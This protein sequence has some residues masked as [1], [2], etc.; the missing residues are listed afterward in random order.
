[1]KLSGKSEKWGIAI[2]G[3]VSAALVVNLGLQLGGFRSGGS[4]AAGAS[5][6]APGARAEN[7]RASDD[8]MKYDPVIH[9]DFLK[10]LQDR[11]MPELE[12]NPF[13]FEPTPAE[14]SA[15]AAAEAARASQPPPPPPVLLKPIGYAERPGGQREA[16]A[17]YQD[18]IYVVH[19]GDT[20]A[21][22]YKVMGIT[23]SRVT[24][25]D[26]STHETLEIPI[27]Q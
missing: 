26:V 13:D 5:S 16:M 9:L 7:R 21:G 27:P 6:A 3:A 2:L 25:T 1:M 4:R 10:Q 14:K 20:V 19:V 8:L 12:R 24:V 17:S 11:P 18:D 15:V 22:K 23:P